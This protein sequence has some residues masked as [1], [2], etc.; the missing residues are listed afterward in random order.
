MLAT[1]LTHP[2][3]SHLTHPSPTTHPSPDSPPTNSEMIM[4]AVRMVNAT[5]YHTLTL[6]RVLGGGWRGLGGTGGMVQAT[7]GGPFCVLAL[8]MREHES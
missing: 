8:S 3:P 2:L 1:S 4:N 7:S 6:G 5:K